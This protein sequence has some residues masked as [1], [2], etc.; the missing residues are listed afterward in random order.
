M[1]EL[2]QIFYETIVKILSN[3]KKAC[4]IEHDNNK[5]TSDSDVSL[6]IQEV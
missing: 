3:Y 4:I 6:K 2:L 1:A 5:E